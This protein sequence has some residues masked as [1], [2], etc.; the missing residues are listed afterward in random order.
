MKTTVEIPD[1][2]F[3]Q[4]KSQAALEGIRLKDLIVRGLRLALEEK[5]SPKGRRT[6]EFPVIQAKEPRSLSLAQ[7]KRALR[8]MEEEEAENVAPSRRR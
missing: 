2:L 4:A 5:N 6:V 8:E 1:A 7:V 3:R